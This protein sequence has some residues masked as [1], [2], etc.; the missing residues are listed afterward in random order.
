MKNACSKF[1]P[2][3]LMQSVCMSS[4]VVFR[5][6]VKREREREREREAFACS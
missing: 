4:L 3:G 6:C 5:V 2:F 1:D